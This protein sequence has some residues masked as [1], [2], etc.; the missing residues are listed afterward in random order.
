MYKFTSYDNWM[1]EAIKHLKPKSE[2]EIRSYLENLSPEEKL[3]EGVENNM[4]WLVKIAIDEG[5]NVNM[6]FGVC[7]CALMN[8]SIFGHTKIIKLLLDAGA[9]PNIIFN[10]PYCGYKTSL[11]AAIRENHHEIVKLLKQYGAKK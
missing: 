5:V 3:I 11:E 2:E 9:N 1:N 8:A 4:P 7:S 6:K 10:D